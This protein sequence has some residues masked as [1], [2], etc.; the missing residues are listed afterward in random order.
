MADKTLQDISET[1]RQIDLC[2]LST[3]S[4][5]G[6]IASRP[7]SNNREVEYE[8]TSRFFTTKDTEMVTDI[9]NDA[10]VAITYQGKD[11]LFI[12]L[13]GK[14]ELIDDKAA[15]E[16]HWVPDLD[17]WFSE[18]VDTPGLRLIEVEAERIHYWDGMDEGEISL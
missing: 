14:A 2:M 1:M 3:H 8:G 5:N 12:T 18:G 16:R 17:R 13:Q 4:P 11:A 7:M 9:E 15:F 6:Q 10:K